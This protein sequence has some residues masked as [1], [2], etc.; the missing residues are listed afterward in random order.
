[1]ISANFRS[2]GNSL[3]DRDRFTIWVTTGS[4]ALKQ[5]FSSQVGIGSRSHDLEADFLIIFAISVSVAGS[6]EDRT[7]CR[8]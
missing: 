7:D 4:N 3:L 6:N 8:Q 1:M 2:D 5:S